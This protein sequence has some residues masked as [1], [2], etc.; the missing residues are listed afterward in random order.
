MKR[1][2]A[3]VLGL[4]QYNEEPNIRVHPT[5]DEIIQIQSDNLYR[6]LADHSQATTEALEAISNAQALASVINKS[7][8]Q[9]KT[10]YELLKVAVE[11]LK[12]K[13]GVKTTG[14][15]LESINELNY[16][17]ES[18]Q[19]VKNFIR[20]VLAAIKKAFLFMIDKIGEFVK[21]LLDR[22]K[23]AKESLAKAADKNAEYIEEI[24]RVPDS[25]N[26]NKKYSG[27]YFKSYPEKE[28][29]SNTTAQK[30][31]YTYKFSRKVADAIG[32][33]QASDFTVSTINSGLNFTYKELENLVDSIIDV[34]LDVIAQEFSNI[35]KAYVNGSSPTAPSWWSYFSDAKL[36]R[37]VGGTIGPSI[38]VSV[39]TG[40]EAIKISKEFVGNRQVMPLNPVEL[41]R[42]TYV[43]LKKYVSLS[44]NLVRNTSRYASS[45]SKFFKDEEAIYNTLDTQDKS[46]REKVLL[47]K[48]ELAT[49][50][51]VVA[52]LFKITKAVD[53]YILSIPAG[54][55]DYTEENLRFFKK[56][57]DEKLTTAR[58]INEKDYS[59][60]INQF[61]FD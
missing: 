22:N 36:N 25:P 48:E 60:Y 6:D 53:D 1:N 28:T 30:Q 38:G 11:Q 5:D 4:E 58:Y 56:M 17:Q 18:L 15:A 32:T 51:R 19:D 10:A 8:T 2:L 49:F 27:D 57:V 21:T 42:E 7:N 20:Q 45:M 50:Q 16:K 12:E 61:K 39:G 34:K 55:L 9:D 37:T 47:I 26:S 46:A 29:A 40:D 59:D 44:E 54:F 14:V 35:S 31:Q 52:N 43:I 13:T 41:D 3:K 24:K 23:R 33:K